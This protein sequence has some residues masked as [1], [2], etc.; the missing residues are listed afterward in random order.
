MTAI[1]TQR[2]PL[3]SRPPVPVT[4]GS[5][6]AVSREVGGLLVTEAHFP[7]GLLLPMH[8]HDRATV[9]IML[10]GS[11]ECAFSGR[12]LACGPGALHTE[13][14]EERHANRV[15][16][17]GAHVVVIQPR[18]QA[19]A[20]LGRQLPVLEAINHAPQTVAIGLGWRL[21]RELAASDAAAP[22]A[23]EGLA[24]EILAEATRAV[25]PATGKGSRWLGK[26]QEYLHANFRRPV[27]IGE[28]ARAVGV[29]PVR[30]ARTFRRR[31]GMS[32]GTYTRGLRIDWAGLQLRSSEK[33]LSAIA[34]QAG[35]AD[36]SHFT[37]AF[38]RQVGVTPHR[39][40][41]AAQ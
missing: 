18:P 33:P 12:V 25:E 36:Q 8:T 32:L 9:A 11:F 17:R 3:P 14:A 39:Y 19:A 28:V 7:A 21:A 13:P 22:L 10:E 38:R 27:T 23:I 5:V 6:Q 31:Y 15:G 34:M 26:A 1:R 41:E 37:R 24:L 4:L 2:S 16:D 30:L 40:R 20:S 29:N 35:F